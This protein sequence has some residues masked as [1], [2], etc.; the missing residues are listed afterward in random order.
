M[1]AMMNAIQLRYAV[2]AR[3]LINRLKQ[4]NLGGISR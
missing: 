4:R 3:G 1:K 2:F